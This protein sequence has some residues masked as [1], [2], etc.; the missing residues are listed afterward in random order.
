MRWK[1]RQ[2]VQ[3]DR[4]TEARKSS[5][6][7]ASSRR[8]AAVALPDDPE[9]FPVHDAV[10]DEP[11]DPGQHVLHVQPAHV[12]EHRLGERCSPAGAPAR[13]GP[14]DGV[15][16]GDEHGRVRVAADPAVLVRPHRTAVGWTTSG[17]G[18]SPSGTSTRPSIARPSD[19]SS[20][21][22]WC[23]QWWRRRGRCRVG[24][25]EEYV[26]ARG[27]PRPGAAAGRALEDEH[28]PPVGPRPPGR[29]GRDPWS[30][31]APQLG[32]TPVRRRRCRR[33]CRARGAR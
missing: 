6:S 30:R 10:G 20:E 9:P 21:G 24:A 23:G 19:E 12:T 28:R 17:C 27:R 7:T 3:G 5:V 32:A 33:R 2:S 11:V 16:A 31:A 14:E 1:E 25:V 18:P 8:E 13:V 22:R 4:A 15:P 29:A 26:G